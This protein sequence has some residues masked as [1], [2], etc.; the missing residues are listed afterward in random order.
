MGFDDRRYWRVDVYKDGE[1]IYTTLEHAEDRKQA[2]RFAHNHVHKIGHVDG[3]FT[4]EVL[5]IKQRNLF[6]TDYYGDISS[7]VPDDTV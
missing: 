2:A 7:I 5:R 1:M 3:F 4:F 6:R